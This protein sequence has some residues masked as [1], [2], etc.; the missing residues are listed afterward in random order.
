MSSSVKP[1]KVLVCI[2]K[3][4]VNNLP[5]LQEFAGFVEV[6]ETDEDG[7]VVQR[8]TGF[9]ESKS[10]YTLQLD[11]DVALEEDCLKEL[12]QCVEGN[13]KA[14]AGAV[15][16]DD[17]S[18]DR[19]AWFT[20]ESK[21]LT[22]LDKKILFY[23]ANGCE[24][25]VSG[26]VSKSVQNFGTLLTD[27]DQICEWLPG[28]CILHHTANLV[29]ENYYPVSGKAYG[30][31]V[32]HSH[33][34]REKGVSLIESHKAKVLVNFPPSGGLGVRGILKVQYQAF[35]IKF[36]LASVLNK[37]RVR[38]TLFTLVYHLVIIKKWLV[39]NA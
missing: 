22:P 9:G 16:Y 8:A 33:L 14:A 4:K 20:P 34:L 30:E 24:G 1:E 10:K 39:R 37:S 5:D 2:G 36:Y 35:K 21:N 25:F 7:Q 17:R 18:G 3:S 32:L 28:C 29:L 23:F 11:S 15:L 13:P 19:H 31:D 27:K 38:L 12:L 26:V 6:L